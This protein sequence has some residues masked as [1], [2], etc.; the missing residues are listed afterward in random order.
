MNSCKFLIFFFLY[1]NLVTMGVPK[2]NIDKKEYNVY[3]SLKIPALV[4]HGMIINRL[5]V[6]SPY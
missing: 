3:K 6:G 2:K 4:D 5:L 1:F